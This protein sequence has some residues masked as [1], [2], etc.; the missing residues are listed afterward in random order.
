MECPRCG[1]TKLQSLK[2]R[3]IGPVK[4]RLRRC[5]HSEESS[6]CGLVFRTHELIVQVQVYNPNSTFDESV[7]IEIYIKKHLDNELK[8]TSGFQHPKMF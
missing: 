2:T 5:Q 4:E 8:G 7:D 1:N 3:N 6:G